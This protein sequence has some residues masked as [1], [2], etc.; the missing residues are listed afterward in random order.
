MNKNT[1]TK[2][3][4]RCGA[5]FPATTDYFFKAIYSSKTGL[6][7][8]CKYCSREGQKKWVKENK[9][10]TNGYT[11]KWRD[12]NLTKEQNT[13]KAQDYRRERAF[14]DTGMT[15]CAI[16]GREY[17]INKRF[18]RHHVDYKT[19][20]MVLLCCPC[21]SWLHG[22]AAAHNQLFKQQYGKDKAP[23][24]F[25]QKVVELYMGHDPEMQEMIEMKIDADIWEKVKGKEND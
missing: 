24:I 6:L 13:K 18:S 12:K 5:T 4:S 15:C 16:C 7:S 20:K 25:A 17:E 9:E 8:E 3:C 22:T 1:P 2:T 11:K 23:L 21:H 10:K 14:K 19:N